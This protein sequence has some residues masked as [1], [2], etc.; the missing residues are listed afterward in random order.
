MGLE[1]SWSTP[2][3]PVDLKPRRAQELAIQG[4]LDPDELRATLAELQETRKTP[5]REWRPSRVAES[6]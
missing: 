4:L 2:E 5:E 1:G 3:W 6:T